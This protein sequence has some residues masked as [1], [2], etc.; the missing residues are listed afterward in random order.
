M[1]LAHPQ[2]GEGLRVHGDSH[3]ATINTRSVKGTEPG[4]NETAVIFFSLSDQS[5]DGDDSSTS[6]EPEFNGSFTASTAFLVGLNETI[7]MKGA[8][9]TDFGKMNVDKTEEKKKKSAKEAT[10]MSWD[11]TATQQLKD[12]SDNL[13]KGPADLVP[14]FAENCEP[15]SLHLSYQIMMLQHKQIQSENKKA[16]IASKQ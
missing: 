9:G 7:S 4:Q 10:A 5:G 8:K 13:C 2:D 15:P 12:N 14:G 6:T 1:A 11:Y 16:R 3:E